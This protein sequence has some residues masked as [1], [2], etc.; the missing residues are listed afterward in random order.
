MDHDFGDISLFHAAISQDRLEPPIDEYLV[1]AGLTASE[2]ADVKAMFNRFCEA[3]EN[4]N[5][6]PLPEI[7]SGPLDVVSIQSSARS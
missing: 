7:A 3:I 6:M 1:S 4:A 2:I 5:A